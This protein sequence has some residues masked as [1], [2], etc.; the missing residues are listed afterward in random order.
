M[1]VSDALKEL[2][3]TWKTKGPS[4]RDVRDRLDDLFNGQV[5]SHEKKGQLLID[6]PAM[7]REN[8]SMITAR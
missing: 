1:A 4:Y 3:V 6:L 5:L 8:R 7:I 2:V